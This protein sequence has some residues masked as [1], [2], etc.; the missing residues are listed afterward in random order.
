[1]KASPNDRDTIGGPRLERFKSSIERIGPMI[2]KAMLYVGNCR[3]TSGR[4]SR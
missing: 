2:V 1:M 3:E 4:D